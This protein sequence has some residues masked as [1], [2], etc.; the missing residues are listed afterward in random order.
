MKN[1]SRLMQGL[2][3][4]LREGVERLVEAEE[5]SVDD[6]LVVAIA[7]KLARYE[8]AVWLQRSRSG[9][10]RTVREMRREALPGFEGRN[11]LHNAAFHCAQHGGYSDA[12]SR[13]SPLDS[14][15]AGTQ[16][17]ELFEDAPV[18]FAVL[19]GPNHVF[20]QANRS[21]RELLGERDLVG[22]RV[23][24][25]MPE[26]VGTEWIDLLDHVYRSGQPRGERGAV[27]SIARAEGEPLKDT[28]VDYTFKPRREANGAISGIIAVGVDATLMHEL[29]QR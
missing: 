4:S 13:L 25:C 17:G 24:D 16:L 14:G 5:S 10:P 15:D 6:L 11:A 21:Y 7:E 28:Y 3:P 26:V 8:H 22:R 18:L 27:L 1:A 19:S 9:L 29:S 2:S 20:E 12:P 23:V